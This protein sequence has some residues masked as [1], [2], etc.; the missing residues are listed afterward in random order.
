MADSSFRRFLRFLRPFYARACAEI[1][2]RAEKTDCARA[3]AAT[4][5]V[6]RTP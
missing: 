3:S 4:A 6:R 1:V 2:A 5:L